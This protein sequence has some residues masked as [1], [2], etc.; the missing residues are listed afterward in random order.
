MRGLD[1]DL[2]VIQDAFVAITMVA[3]DVADGIARMGDFLCPADRVL[4]RRRAPKMADFC[5]SLVPN[6]TLHSIY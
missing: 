2:D 4:N 1:L 3:R 5:Y 6:C